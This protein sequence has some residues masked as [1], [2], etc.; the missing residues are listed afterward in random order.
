MEFPTT[1][2]QIMALHLQVKKYY[3]TW[4]LQI[5]PMAFPQHNPLKKKKKKKNCD[6]RDSFAK[7]FMKLLGKVFRSANAEHRVWDQQLARLLLTYRANPH[8]TTGDMLFY[9][10]GRF[11]GS[12]QYQRRITKY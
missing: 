5:H 1:S 8:P 10:T 2:N 12:Y 6:L 11:V 4:Y 9:L 7:S 3:V